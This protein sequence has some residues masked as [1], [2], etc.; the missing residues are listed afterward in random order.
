MRKPIHKPHRLVPD[1]VYHNL[2]VT[3]I[4]NSSLKDGKKSAAQTQVYSAL[5]II[6]K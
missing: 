3:K 1:P 5:E 2:L 4:I 6:K